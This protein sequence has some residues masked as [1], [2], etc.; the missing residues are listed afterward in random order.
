[1]GSP[2][3]LKQMN[4]RKEQVAD[5]IRSILWLIDAQDLQNI[6]DYGVGRQVPKEYAEAVCDWAVQF[7]NAAEAILQS[8]R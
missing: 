4:V 1:M 7:K 6:G 2:S 3:N 5:W 8:R